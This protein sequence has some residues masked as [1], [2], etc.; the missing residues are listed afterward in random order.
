MVRMGYGRG[1]YG[2]LYSDVN[3]N[4][5]EGEDGVVGDGDADGPP[6]KRPPVWKVGLGSKR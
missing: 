5:G 1:S 6:R 3:V 4:A 2:R